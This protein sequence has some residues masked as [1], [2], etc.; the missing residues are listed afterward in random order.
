MKIIKMK[1]GIN[2]HETWLTDDRD[3]RLILYYDDTI[4]FNFNKKKNVGI[5]RCFPANYPR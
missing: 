5:I 4:V 1:D 2:F 3:I